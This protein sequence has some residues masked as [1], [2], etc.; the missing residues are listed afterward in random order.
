[1]N[2]LSYRIKKENAKKYFFFLAFLFYSLSTYS[3]ANNYAGKEHGYYLTTGLRIQNNTSIGGIAGIQY[4]SSTTRFGG[5][6]RATLNYSYEAINSTGISQ[7]H[8]FNYYVELT[9]DIFY[10]KNKPFVLSFGL[11]KP[12]FYINPYKEYP[13]GFGYNLTTSIQRNIKAINLELRFDLPIG[14]P[15]YGWYYPNNIFFIIDLSYSF[16]PF[17]RRTKQQ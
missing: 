16:K 3:Q 1:M 12:S 10:Y 9:A 6:L 4:H 7:H 8:V 13:Y 14:N 11:T 15:Y 5:N 17:T 2:S